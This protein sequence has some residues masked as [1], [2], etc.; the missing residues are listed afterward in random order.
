LL[1]YE[2]E[3][4]ETEIKQWFQTIT[5]AGVPLNEQ[6]LLNAIYPGPF[7]TAAKA[8]FSNSQNANIAK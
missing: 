8:A 4:T 1:I 6:E 7:V 5:I 3:G 2:C